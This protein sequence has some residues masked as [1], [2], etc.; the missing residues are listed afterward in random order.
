LG[1]AA[2]EENEAAAIAAGQN[3][4]T[5][6]NGITF[7]IESQTE[8]AD[9][10]DLFR[11]TQEGL[12]YFIHETFP[13]FPAELAGAHSVRFTL[14]AGVELPGGDIGHS[15]VFSEETGECILGLC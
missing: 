15:R 8:F 5:A 4:I 11:F 7:N 9:Q 12:S 14:G 6:D 3:Q 10:T 13:R 1:Q 2:R